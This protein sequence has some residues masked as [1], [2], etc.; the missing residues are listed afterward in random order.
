[1]RIRKETKE[2]AQKRVDM[3]KAMDALKDSDYQKALEKVETK[4]RYLEGSEKQVKW[5]KDILEAAAKEPIPGVIATLPAWRLYL[6]A[7]EI[8]FVKATFTAGEI[9]NSLQGISK[10]AVQKKALEI[11]G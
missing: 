5:A 7:S 8:A 11:L 2:E 9:I 10:E 1:M 6:T 3:Y 4:D